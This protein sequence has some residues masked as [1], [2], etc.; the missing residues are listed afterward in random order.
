MAEIDIVDSW[1]SFKMCPT[2]LGEDY[3]APHC[4]FSVFIAIDFKQE[5][6]WICMF[7]TGLPGANPAV[8]ST[9]SKLWMDKDN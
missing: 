3:C 9:E 6:L 5:T 1:V 4:T 8:H 2:Y 7:N